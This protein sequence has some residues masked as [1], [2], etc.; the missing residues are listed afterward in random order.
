MNK[1]ISSIK[2]IDRALSVA[3]T[4]GQ[5]GPGSNGNEGMLQILQT[6]SITGTFSSYCLVSSQ[7]TRWW[8]SY[9]SAEVQSVHSAAPTDW[10]KP[11]LGH[12]M[13]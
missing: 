3:T 5:R 12:F 6:S 11:L 4:P 7:D 10:E 1:Q 9:S 13:F 2:H 8:G